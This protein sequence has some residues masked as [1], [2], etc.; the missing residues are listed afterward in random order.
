MI[1]FSIKSDRKFIE[2]Y[3]KLTDIYL[4]SKD[5]VY[6]GGK[7]SDIKEL[8]IN[9][10]ELRQSLARGLPRVKRL[11]NLFSVQIT[12]LDLSTGVHANAFS[13]ILNDDAR[14]LIPDYQKLDLLNET[15]GCC[16][17][18][19]RKELFQ[20]INPMY[21]IT[22]A[23]TKVLRLP[24]W[25]LETAGFKTSSFEKSLAGSVVRLIELILII[26]LLMYIGFSES[27]LKDVVKEYL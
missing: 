13:T 5:N 10:K 15:I 11:A 16:I 17:E 25:V 8:M 2:N 9:T 21:W 12:A 3:Y 24:F 27:E 6:S 19:E 18:Q 1:Y 26:L 14:G 22:L 23:I 7:V 4:S 20:F